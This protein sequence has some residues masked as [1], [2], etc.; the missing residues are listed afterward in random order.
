MSKDEAVEVESGERIAES[1]RELWEARR[2][3]NSQDLIS[4]S[5]ASEWIRKR[6]DFSGSEGY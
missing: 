5:S 6:G 3:E 2:V 4:C 1:P